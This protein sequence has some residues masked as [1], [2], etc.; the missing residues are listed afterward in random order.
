MET[1]VITLDDEPAR[2]TV[3][4]T[5]NIIV[6]AVNDPPEI[7]EWLP[8]ELELEVVIDTTITF[9]VV[10]E[11]V[12]SDV[13]YSWYV[14]EIEQP[15]IEDEFTFTFAETGE[16][17]IQC[18]AYDEA[19]ERYKTWNITAIQVDNE[20]SGFFQATALTGNYPNPFNPETVIRYCVQPEDLPAVLK[21]FNLKGQNLRTWK[22]EQSGSQQITWDGCDGA[23]KMQASGVYIYQLQSGAGIDSKRMLLLK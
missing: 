13:G 15:E 6:E 14:N 22:I 11:D 5:L 18:L 8:E 21:V 2:L 3:S 7:V 1:I 4:D 16:Y 10:V 23:G 9:S 17:E 20:P 12:D 19:E